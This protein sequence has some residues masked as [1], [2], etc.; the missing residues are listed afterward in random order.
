M[1][2]SSAVSV[3]EAASIS[4]VAFSLPLLNDTQEEPTEAPHKRG[5]KGEAFPPLSLPKHDLN[6]VFS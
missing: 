1:S 4:D 2:Q 6:S 5:R 3:S